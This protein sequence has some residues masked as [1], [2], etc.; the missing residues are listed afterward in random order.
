MYA[1]SN[2]P[3]AALAQYALAEPVFRQT[4]DVNRQAMLYNNIGYVYHMVLQQW[5]EAE[6]FYRLSIERAREIGNVYERC[7]ALDNLGLAYAAQGRYQEAEAVFEEALHELAKIEHDPGYQ[8]L[9]DEVAT[10]L[11]QARQ[12]S[13]ASL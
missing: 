4:A 7:N 6:H 9:V 13:V 12:Q 1:L 8:Q 3:A 11:N 2:D 10:H 5:P